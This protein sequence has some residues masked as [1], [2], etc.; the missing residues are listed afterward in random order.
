[1]IKSHTWFSNTASG[2]LQKGRRV[3]TD[4]CDCSENV[5]GHNKDC[6]SHEIIFKNS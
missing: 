6:A 4:R 3:K 5:T 2:E 1:M